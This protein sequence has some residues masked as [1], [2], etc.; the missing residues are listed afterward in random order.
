MWTQGS[1]DTKHWYLHL[2]NVD[3]PSP[4]LPPL[5][6]SICIIYTYNVCAVCLRWLRVSAKCLT[7]TI[8]THAYTPR[9]WQMCEVSRLYRADAIQLFTEIAFRPITLRFDFC[10]PHLFTSSRWP[11]IANAYGSNFKLAVNPKIGSSR[12]CVYVCVCVCECC[13]YYI[14][15]PSLSLSLSLSL[16]SFPSHFSPAYT[17]FRQ[18]QQ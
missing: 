12:V 11:T 7:G 1:N 17:H 15:Y 2:P 4:A 9:V 6:L 14:L 8:C 3:P 13:L 18:Q 16:S 5:C 10:F